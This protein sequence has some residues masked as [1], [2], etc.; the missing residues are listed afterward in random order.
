MRGLW[1][2]PLKKEA[3]GNHPPTTTQ[4]LKQ[5]RTPI[6]V[7]KIPKKYPIVTSDRPSDRA[8]P[9]L[10]ARTSE[11]PMAQAIMAK[12]GKGINITPRIPMASTAGPLLP[13]G[14]AGP[15]ATLRVVPT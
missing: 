6:Q 5:I 4:Q 7:P 9:R 14:T 3:V 13:R 11:A 8:S 12:T 2:Q 10:I 1:K 15:G